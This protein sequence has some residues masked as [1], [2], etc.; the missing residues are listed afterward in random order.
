[1]IQVLN[2]A[3]RLGFTNFSFSSEGS[4]PIGLDNLI[5][6]D[7]ATTEEISDAVRE[8]K[9]FMDKKHREEKIE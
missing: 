4:N 7:A 9:S 8:I 2:H 1:M 3:R 5:D 6:Y